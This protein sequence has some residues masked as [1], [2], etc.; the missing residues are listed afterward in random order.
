MFSHNF[1]IVLSANVYFLTIP[2]E[3]QRS[4]ALENQAEKVCSLL[5]AGGCSGYSGTRMTGPP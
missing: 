3:S 4:G 1:G 2:A 5:E